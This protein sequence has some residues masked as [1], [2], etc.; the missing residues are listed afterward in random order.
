MRTP[1]HEAVSI[2][3][4]CEARGRNGWFTPSEMSV[5]RCEEDQAISLSVRSSRP[6][7]DMP[8]VYLALGLADARSLHAALGRQIADLEA[9]AARAVDGAV[10][11]R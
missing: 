2:T 4:D 8:P 5:Q 9:T 11:R 1:I 3:C 6:Y 10:S 7:R